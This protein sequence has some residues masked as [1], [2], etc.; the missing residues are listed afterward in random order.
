MVTAT[1]SR[2]NGL[3]IALQGLTVT[4]V[5]VGGAAAREGVQ[6]GDV[7]VQVNGKDAAKAGVLSTLLPKDKM[8]PVKLRLMREV[9]PDKAGGPPAKTAA[10]K[11]PGSPSSVV[12]QKQTSPAEAGATSN[13]AAA[14]AVATAPAPAPGP[15]PAPAQERTEQ[16]PASEDQPDEPK[17]LSRPPPANGEPSAVLPSADSSS[18]NCL[19]EWLARCFGQ[20]AS[21]RAMSGNRVT[22]KDLRARFLTLD[23]SHRW[24]RSVSQLDPRHR[25]VDFLRPGG[26][27][28]PRGYLRSKG[29]IPANDSKSVPSEFFAVFRPTSYDALRMMMMGMG[30]GKGLNVKGK[31]AKQG[32]LRCPSTPPPHRPRHPHHQ[33]RAVLVLVLPCTCLRCMRARRSPPFLRAS[34]LASAVPLRCGF[35]TRAHARTRTRTLVAACRA[36]LIRRHAVAALPQRLRPFSANLDGGA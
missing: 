13:A 19:A 32:L 35:I 29:R 18:P 12:K 23:H 31:S 17:P 30:T 28:G 11:T 9:I 4:E 2:V 1:V 3:G 14:P 22:R 7:I 33:A 25:I 10:A 21:S 34:P 24:L 6:V 16:A 36:S 26:E 15:A 8:Q 27:E 5:H 20:A